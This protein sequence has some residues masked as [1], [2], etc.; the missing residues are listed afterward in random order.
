V[1]WVII[2]L[3]KPRMRK[4]QLEG[5]FDEKVATLLHDDLSDFGTHVFIGERSDLYSDPD[6]AA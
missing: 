6:A 2:N 1:Q 3:H 5:N 4:L